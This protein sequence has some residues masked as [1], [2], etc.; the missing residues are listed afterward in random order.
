MQ[1]LPRKHIPSVSARR[2]AKRS[3]IQSAAGCALTMRLSRFV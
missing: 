1:L 3:A 2:A